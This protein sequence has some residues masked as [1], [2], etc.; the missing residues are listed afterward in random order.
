MVAL[1][2]RIRGFPNRIELSLQRQCIERIDS[3]TRKQ[4]DAGIELAEGA[5]ERPA[6]FFLRA[7]DARRILDAPVRGH[8]LARPY[9]A[10]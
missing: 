8:R 4:L 10:L 9:R 7:C 1:I 2:Q 6:L 3:Q 5:R